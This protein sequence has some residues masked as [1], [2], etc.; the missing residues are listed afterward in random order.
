MGKILVVDDQLGIR[1]LLF[2][3]FKEDQHE[4]EMAA[5]GTEALSCLFPLS[6]ISY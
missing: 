6:Q 4:V 5:N 3:I 1:R 2:D